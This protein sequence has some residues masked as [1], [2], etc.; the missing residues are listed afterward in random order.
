MRRVHRWSSQNEAGDDLV[1]VRTRSLVL[2]RM[3]LPV[4][5]RHGGEVDHGDEGEGVEVVG[6]GLD[7][8]LDG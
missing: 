4:Q 5:L 7:W 8:T 1:G 2:V 6:V 3:G